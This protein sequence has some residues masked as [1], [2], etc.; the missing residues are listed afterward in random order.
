MATAL[1]PVTNGA[2]KVLHL[3]GQTVGGDSLTG[4]DVVVI[5][6]K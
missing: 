1:G 2:V 4:E 6:K 3:T 5:K